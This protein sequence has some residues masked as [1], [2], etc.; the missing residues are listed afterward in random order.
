[1]RCRWLLLI[2]GRAFSLGCLISADQQ[3]CAIRAKAISVGQHGL[4]NSQAALGT[5]QQWR[6]EEWGAG[7]IGCSRHVLVQ[8]QGGLQVLRDVSAKLGRQSVPAVARKGRR[9][10]RMHHA[11][12]LLPSCN[13]CADGKGKTR[14]CSPPSSTCSVLGGAGRHGV[15]G[16]DNPVFPSPAFV[17]MLLYF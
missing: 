16:G 14:T 4:D 10:W 5:R 6:Q 9:A 12:G 8:G 7:C 17:P 15:R 3:R 11:I 1:M 2:T 13:A